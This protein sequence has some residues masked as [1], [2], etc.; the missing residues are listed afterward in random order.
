MTIAL[1]YITAGLIFAGLALL[2]PH[3]LPQLLLDWTAISLLV[4]SSAYW[5][6]SAAV[7]RKRSDG[8]L[9]WYSRWLFIPFFFGT[10][11]FNAV[12]R[13]FDSVPAIQRISGGLYLGAR[14]TERD[15]QQLTA[16]G[17][18]AV[19]DVTAEF[20]ALD[21]ASRD[22]DIQYLN[23]PVLDHAPPTE[24]QL[25]QAV[26]WL[27][28]QQKQQKKIVV[29]CALGRGRS[30]LVLAAFLLS[31]Q[32]DRSAERAVALIK[33]VRHTANLN[34]RQLAALRNF[35]VNYDHNMHIKAWLIANPVSGGG[36]WVAAEPDI[37]EQ[38][39]P[40]MTLT[41]KTTSETLSARQ[42]AKQ[43]KAA[44]AN[45]IIACGG[46]G[47]VGEVAAELVTT[48][49]PLGIIPLGTTNAFS[50]ALWGISAK[51]MPVRS[52][53]LNIIEGQSKAID[54]ARCNDHIMLLLAGLGF[55][56]Q[57]IE[58]ADRERKNELGQLAYLEGFWQAVQ[59]NAMQPLNIQLD[60]G[61]EQ[62]INTSSL[63]IA[64]A[65]PITTL[66]AQGKGAPDMTDGLL[67]VTWIIHNGDDSSAISSIAELAFTGLTQISLESGN[68]QH[69]RAQRVQISTHDEFKYVI[70]G[71][72]FSTNHLDIKVLPASLL[73][74]LP[75]STE[76]TVASE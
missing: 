65:A 49:I 51:L 76:S 74:M 46:D 63:I 26:K 24:A 38:L 53:C 57:M 69:C 54:T 32:T 16:E 34:T 60:D 61:E 20:S 52:A 9:P 59:S 33:E 5:L 37:V 8:S 50:H 12:A 18:T 71:E 73:I 62:T 25:N 36:K 40:H 75:T 42:L 4:V 68:I 47:T 29:H 22:K 28:L 6:N 35:A 2:T 58:A 7:F 19:L 14:L 17:I 72:P 10:H 3:W 13:R 23:I 45:L 66:L 15:L 48:D 1:R 56:Q 64:N 44:G 30:V 55:E 27:H 11:V 67:D 31:R 39:T 41:V 43:A 21:W 70:D